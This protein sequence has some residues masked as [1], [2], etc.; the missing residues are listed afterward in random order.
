MNMLMNIGIWGHSMIFSR[1]GNIR[2]KIQAR[3]AILTLLSTLI[4]SVSFAFGIPQIASAAPMPAGAMQDAYQGHAM[5]MPKQMTCNRGGCTDEHGA[6]DNHC[7]DRV[8]DQTIPAALTSTG[9]EQTP[10]GHISPL[11]L[12]RHDVPDISFMAPPRAPP[13]HIFLRPVIKRE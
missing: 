2:M 3:I 4:I 7:I 13:T 12:K 8:P 11:T 9:A 10:V 1:D 5:P 6:C